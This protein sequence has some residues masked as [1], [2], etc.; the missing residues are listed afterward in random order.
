MDHDGPQTASPAAK[1]LIVDDHPIVREGLS[2]LISGSDDLVVCGEAEDIPSALRLAEQTAPD[3]V[4]VDISLKGG[5]G[6]DLIKRIKS[7]WP[8]V[9]VLV[10]SMHGDALYAERAVRAGASGY[11]NKQE[12][13]RTILDAIRTVLDGKLCLSAT[14]TERL[15]R[16]AVGQGG[17]GLG[18]S[19]LESLSDRE[20]EVLA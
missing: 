15:L 13:T 8:S 7:R 17:E 11:V 12:A 6:I 1:I 14:L 20:L 18:G 19:P 10:S 5:N 16:R 9:R 2:L 3:L 4:V